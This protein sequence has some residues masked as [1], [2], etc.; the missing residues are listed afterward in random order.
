MGHPRVV[1]PLN[2]P[3][4]RVLVVKILVL[5]VFNLF[6][7]RVIDSVSVGGWSGGGSGAGEESG[8]PL[9]PALLP[10]G[11]AVPET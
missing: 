4:T 11:F 10:R 9:V 8:N 5:A 1:V 3:A 7:K 6:V 2:E